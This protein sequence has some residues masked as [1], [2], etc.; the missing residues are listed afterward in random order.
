MVGFPGE[1]DAAFQNT[2]AV[3]T[4]LPFS[5]L[6]VF[7]YSS[8]PGTAATAPE[9][10]RVSS[11][12]VKKRTDLLLDLDRAKRLAFHNKQIG[13]TVSVLFEAGHSRSY[14]FGT[15]P[16]F[17]KVAVTEIQA[18]FRIRSS[19]SRLPPQQTVVTFRPSRTAFQHTHAA[20]VVL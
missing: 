10:A 2:L 6:H 18:T 8:R 19:R 20:L 14:R 15:T 4:D 17:T 9:A 16:N 3:A 13:K 11:A 7:P 12:S 1:T 5:Y